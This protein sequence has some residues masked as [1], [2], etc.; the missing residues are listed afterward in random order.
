MLG[1]LSERALR[2]QKVDRLWITLSGH[3]APPDGTVKREAMT[4]PRSI[5]GMTLIELLVVVGI[6]VLVI[7]LLLPAF[8]GA[9]HATYQTVCASNLRQIGMAVT[10]YRDANGGLLPDAQPFPA[11]PVKP[12]VMDA[13]AIH[14]EDN[15]DIWRCAADPDLFETYGTSY[16]Y[17]IGFYLIQEAMEN[18]LNPVQA[19]RRFI[20][21]MD[22]NA[23][24]AFIMLDADD[25]HPG[26]HASAQRNALFLDG[27]VD[28][29]HVP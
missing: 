29:F 25:F 26:G 24:F 7:G 10:Q 21:Q 15:D 23:S 9:R 16:E 28:W 22:N 2:A 11:D 14:L 12:V 19:Q 3:N 17:L 5:Q 1:I 27:H 20:K 8:S 13:F 18:P 6:I 4:R